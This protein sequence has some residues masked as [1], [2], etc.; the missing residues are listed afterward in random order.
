MTSKNTGL[1]L[2]VAA[3]VQVSDDVVQLTL[4]GATPLPPWEPG[5]H[6]DV[7]CGEHRRQY[8]LCGNPHARDHYRIAVLREPRGRGGS[9][10]LHDCV[11][12]TD[13]LQVSLP[14]NTFALVPAGR[15]VFI[16]GG[17][18]ITPILPMV[19][20]AERQGAEWTLMYGGRTRAAMAFLDELAAY[21]DRV[22]IHPQDEAGLLPVTDLL[23]E[24]VAGTRVYCCGPAPLL[25]AVVRLSSGWPAGSL[26]VEHF[27]PTELDAEAERGF[28][29]RLAGSGATHHVPSDR[30]ILEVLAEAGVP[31][32]SSCEVG[33]CGTCETVVLEGVPDHRDAVLT[34]DE[35]A[36]GRY[37]MLCVSRSLS[38]TL[39]LDI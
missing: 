31:V 28:D 3:K 12:T 14:R 2:R 19:A 6:I 36:E 10:Y 15:Y 25:D 13:R 22:T 29:V 33:N 18:G 26:H 30:T 16:A 32:G 38:D 5:A 20:E 1:T 35:R 11:S 8:S 4:T 34:P 7:E 21:G 37:M 9:A 17:I 39:V 24:P 23:A 27:S